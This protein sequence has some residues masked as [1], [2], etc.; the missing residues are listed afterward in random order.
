MD[1]MIAGKNGNC[2]ERLKEVGR[3][4][5]VEQRRNRFPRGEKQ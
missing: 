3:N 2:V 5:A 1:L 4:I